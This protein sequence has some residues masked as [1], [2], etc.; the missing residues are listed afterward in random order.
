M[1]ASA[2]AACSCAAPSSACAAVSAVVLFLQALER[3]LGVGGEGFLAR[4]VG[5]HLHQPRFGGLAR[6]GDAALFFFQRALRL[7]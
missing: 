3:G 2:A 6:G 4:D 1:A 5:A 7:D